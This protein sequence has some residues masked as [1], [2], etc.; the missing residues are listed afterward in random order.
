M[1]IGKAP[2][3]GIAEYRAP[4]I[5]GIEKTTKTF[6]NSKAKL[7]TFLD[8]EI[9]AKSGVPSPTTYSVTKKWEFLD[10]Q[11]RG[12]FLKKTR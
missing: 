3:F 8:D 2:A 7:Q 4:K 9:K 1:S 6:L 11:K 12:I 10:N 5:T